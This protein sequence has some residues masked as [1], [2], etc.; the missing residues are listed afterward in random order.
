MDTTRKV[1]WCGLGDFSMRLKVEALKKTSLECPKNHSV[2]ARASQ[3]DKPVQGLHA[4][5][6]Q[7][8][9]FYLLLAKVLLARFSE[10]KKRKH[11]RRESSSE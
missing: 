7:D 1:G 11:K 3:R 4:S 8:G 6:A 5:N 2:K 10:K 9:D